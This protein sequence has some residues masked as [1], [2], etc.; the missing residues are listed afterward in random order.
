MLPPTDPHLLHRA[1][2]DDDGEAWAQIVRDYTPL[3]RRFAHSIGWYQ[4]HMDELIQEVMLTLVR[5]RGEFEYDPRGRFRNYLFAVV[6][7]CAF[8]LG[9]RITR[10]GAE[11]G[12]SALIDGLAQEDGAL[13]RAWDAQWE[14]WHKQRAFEAVSRVVNPSHWAIFL[15]VAV[16]GLDPAAVAEKHGV[17][18]DNVYQIKKR[19]LEAIRKQ[20]QQQ[21]EG[22]ELP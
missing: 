10:D 1:F 17:S 7:N 6:R 5:K 14:L 15:D 11:N 9:R 4:Q 8:G 18:I 12:H 20:I 13:A 22:E 16:A 19:I 3:I 2:S 21:I